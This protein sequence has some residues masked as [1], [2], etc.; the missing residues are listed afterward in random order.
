MNCF[1]L[2]DNCLFTSVTS[3]VT[4]DNYKNSYKLS[5]P[6]V[7][8]FFFIVFTI[9]TTLN[10]F[11]HFNHFCHF[12]YFIICHY[13]YHFYYFYVLQ[14]KLMVSTGLQNNQLFPALLVSLLLTTGMI[15]CV[16]SCHVMLCYV[17]LCY[18]TLCNVMLCYVMLCYVM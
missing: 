4:S 1:L 17:M 10:H 9:S 13:F 3:T 15:G 14:E 7:S 11:N 18:V 12:L 8:E 6:V 16:I 2:N 5:T